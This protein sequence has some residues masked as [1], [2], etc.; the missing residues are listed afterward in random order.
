LIDFEVRMPL[1]GRIFLLIVCLGNL[2]IAADASPTRAQS[3]TPTATGTSESPPVLVGAGDIAVCGTKGA[4]QTAALIDR[5][6]G[7]V[8]TA[9][10]NVYGSGTAV[11]FKQCYEPTWG[12]F[13]DRT[14]PALGNHD[15]LTKKGAPYFVYFGAAAG[16]PGQGWYSYDLGAWHVVVIDSN[17]AGDR[18]SIQGKWL[19]ADLTAAAAPCTVA[20]WHHPLF[21]SGI[22]GNDRRTY[23]MW[24]ILYEHGADIVINGHDHDY[25]RFAPQTPEGKLDAAKGIREFVVGTGGGELYPFLFSRRNSEVRNNNTWGVFKLILSPD[26]YEWEFIPVEGKTFTDSGSLNCHTAKP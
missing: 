9:G 10:D 8:F 12:R 18:T 7:T 5:I 19:Q 25:E 4:A 17:T 1:I 3:A 24:Q 15:I 23:W 16:T 20:I 6:P 26:H 11:E 13:K 22:H 21:S 14:R 2:W